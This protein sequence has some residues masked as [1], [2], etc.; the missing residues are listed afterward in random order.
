[1]DG[2]ERADPAGTLNGLTRGRICGRIVT[3]V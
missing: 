1:M 2:V 3:S